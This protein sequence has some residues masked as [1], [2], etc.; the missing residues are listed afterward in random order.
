[1]RT[2]FRDLY[3]IF[4]LFS[5]FINTQKYFIFYVFL[6]NIEN[7]GVTNFSSELAKLNSTPLLIIAVFEY[8]KNRES[9]VSVMPIKITN[10]VHLANGFLFIMGELKN[11][12]ADC[13]SIFRCRFV[14][15]LSSDLSGE[16]F[17]FV[18]LPLQMKFSS[19]VS[20]K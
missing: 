1:M 7:W 4:Y 6:K 14:P 18:I 8:M 15:K 16:V 13:L 20:F 19:A 3:F 17:F 11:Y 5:R 12:I 9:S 2:L 10:S